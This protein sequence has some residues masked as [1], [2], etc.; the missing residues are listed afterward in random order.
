VFVLNELVSVIMLKVSD[1]IDPFVLFPNE[2][3]AGP[4]SDILLVRC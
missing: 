2:H 3:S 4:R 1:Q